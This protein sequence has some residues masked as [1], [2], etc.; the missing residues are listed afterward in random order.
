VVASHQLK[1]KNR[2]G[3]LT[4]KEAGQSR[5]EQFSLV[6]QVL[7]LLFTL[8]LS[9]DF[10]IAA[11]SERAFEDFAEQTRAQTEEMAVRT[12]PRLFLNSRVLSLLRTNKSLLIGSA[13]KTCQ[14]FK[15]VWDLD[16]AVYVF[17]ALGNCAE[18]GPTNP[19]H[20]W[21]MK[22]LYKGLTLPPG[23]ERDLL[24]KHIDKKIPFAFGDGKDLDLLQ[25]EKGKVIEVFANGKEGLLAWNSG[26]RG[27]SIVYCSNVPSDQTIFQRGRRAKTRSDPARSGFGYQGVFQFHDAAGAPDV[28]AGEVFRVLQRDKKTCG[29]Y[30]MLWWVF[31][32]TNSGRIVFGA[33]SPPTTTYAETRGGLLCL[34]LA[35]GMFCA[36]GIIGG[37]WAAGLQLRKALIG[38]FL[39]SALVP[40]V[41][42]VLGAGQVVALQEHVAGVR[43][44]TGQQE[45]LTG[46]IRGFEE[47]LNESET[48]FEKILACPGTGKDPHVIDTILQNLRRKGLLQKLTFRDAA[49]MALYT[50]TPEYSPDR[51]ALNRSLARVSIERY[52]PQRA[53]ELP[54]KAN[55][56]TD[57]LVQ[58]NDM[59]FNELIKGYREFQIVQLGN[60]LLL[61]Y[62]QLYPEQKGGVA[63]AEI[64]L[65][66]FQG[67]RTYFRKK[68]R[69]RVAYDTLGMRVYAFHADTQRWTVPPPAHLR[70]P[71][72]KLAFRSMMSGQ[73][74]RGH[75]QQ[76]YR[77]GFAMSLFSQH[78]AG[79]CLVAFCSDRLLQKQASQF[80]TFFL[81]GLI[82]LLGALGFLSQSISRSLLEPLRDLED[83]AGALLQRDFTFRLADAGNNEMGQLFRA[84]NDMMNESRDIQVAKIVQEGLIPREFPQE[85]SFCIQ[86]KIW[87]ASDLGGDCLDCFRLSDGRILFL[88]GDVAGHGVGSALLMAFARAVTFHWSE[89]NSLTPGL[90][91]TELDRSLR[92][93]QGSKDFLG[94]LCGILDPVSH[95]AEITM[96]GQVYPLLLRADGRE[97]WIESRK[98]VAQ[99]IRFAPGDAL[100]CCTDGFIEA[101]NEHQEPLGIERF[102]T[103]ARQ[104]RSAD[105]FAW[106]SRFPAFLEQWAG[107]RREDDMTLLLM[108]RKEDSGS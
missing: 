101:R 1:G 27:G 87:M 28:Q 13:A 85:K 33:Y 83:G 30:K 67:I 63:H 6:L 62:Y 36:W 95:T 64:R 104:T 98:D 103:Q 56:I 96:Q 105:P 34:G 97:E 66:L 42:A 80:R 71:L 72:E 7:L 9:L 8:L 79:H 23:A 78:L 57:R 18:T 12:E 68:I 43:I 61:R 102:A 52:S 100:I 25:A 74:Q 35:F 20:L 32:E 44:S 51:E 59:G 19:P 4:V 54:Y 45:I 38:L 14:Q 93:R 47:F 21:L 88:V 24:R 40:L 11:R 10:W 49:G 37:K 84:F 55:A 17:D 76:G 3:A 26:P 94:L 48:Q 58:T 22:N 108:Q 90:L 15:R 106:F 39:A 89:G 92:Q 60:H 69:Q 99:T 86:G 70:L 41:G 16:I 77:S 5:S 31:Q 73:V 107:Q 65:P 46:I 91:V 29:L 82:V 75:I 53:A 81:V 50:N 2:R